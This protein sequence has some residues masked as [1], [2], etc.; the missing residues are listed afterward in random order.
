M[1]QIKLSRLIFMIMILSLFNSCKKE[2]P[3]PLPEVFTFPSK[4]IHKIVV[5]N[6]GVK[7]FA[8]EK[9]VISYDGSKWTRYSDDKNLTTGSVTDF[10]FDIA[11]GIKKLWLAT[12]VGTSSYEF[13]TTAISVVN[14]SSKSS[15]ILSDSITAVGI[16]QANVKYF[17]TSKG[18]SIFNGTKWDKYLGRTNEVI[19]SRFK[20]SSV[21]TATNGYTYA[22]T[23]GGGV[24]RF[25]YT[26]A[27][28]GETTLNK[29]WAW[30][31][32]SDTVYTVVAD[33]IA[34][35]Y[36][37]NRG[38]GYHSTQDTKT[39]WITYTR[40]DGLVCDTV[41]AIAKD[42][43]GSMWFGTHLGVSKFTVDKWL[44]YTI[45]D[46]LVANKVNTIAVDADGS[47]WFGTDNGI[48]HLINNQW[49]SY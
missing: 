46:G 13:G 32:P 40:A 45:K 4:V 30:G 26:D 6:T 12:F 7:W 2:T 8:T 34:Q 28:S 19:L 41:N 44:N 23:Q 29:P 48:S 42:L 10:A 17:G 39:D 37:T 5:D 1:N 16:D 20:I 9:G 49:I 25:K 38:I 33:G 21:S 3:A 35:W 36:G 18:L 27:V 15:G 47:I 11:S 31:L 43:T 14:Y 24:S 22:A